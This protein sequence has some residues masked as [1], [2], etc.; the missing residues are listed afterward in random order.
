M[1]DLPG[2]VSN[3]Q[4]YLHTKLAVFVVLVVALVIIMVVVIRTFRKT[5]LV[6]WLLEK[7]SKNN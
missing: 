4:L 6:L 1:V 3:K 7:L 5:T 2:P